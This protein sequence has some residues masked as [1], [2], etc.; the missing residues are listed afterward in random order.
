MSFGQRQIHHSTQY[1]GGCLNRQIPSLIPNSYQDNKTQPNIK[2]A[3]DIRSMPPLIP[4]K[5]TLPRL[6]TIP[7]QIGGKGPH[8]NTAQYDSV[9]SQPKSNMTLPVVG[10]NSF[11]NGYGTARVVSNNSPTQSNLMGANSM[12]RDNGT[13][14]G[15]SNNSP[16]QSN[17]SGANFTPRDN[18]RTR[19]VSNNSPP[20]SN[21]MGAN[22][23][24]G[25]NG[26][27]RGLSNNS[28]PQ[29][30]G[31]KRKSENSNR[32]LIDLVKLQLQQLNR[33]LEVLEKNSHSDDDEMLH[34]QLTPPRND[35]AD[36][37]QGT[38]SLFPNNMNTII[39]HDKFCLG[40]E[41]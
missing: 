16:P 6:C 35:V 11:P 25:D 28:P 39:P 7:Q 18:G 38:N 17:M 20:Q 23:S 27:T 8:N 2:E 29:S 9:Q 24:H 22:S 37:Q 19:G 40:Y 30:N 21:L 3:N 32:E 13:T 1:N 4:V 36:F 15:V 10:A 33:T 34:G 5:H 26:T 41:M 31:R 14:H 12:Y